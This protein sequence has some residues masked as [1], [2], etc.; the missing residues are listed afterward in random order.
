MPALHVIGDPVLHSRSPLIQ[1]AMLR[2]LGLDGEYTYTAVPVKKGELPAFLDLARAE[3][4]AGF[5]A[6]MPHKE[7]LVPLMDELDE[8]ARAIGAVNTVCLRGGKLVGH[9]TDGGGLVSALA[10]G[11][12]E[13]AGKTVV[14]LGAGGAAKAVAPALA[15]AGAA[16]VTVCNRT[17]DKASALCARAPGVL[18]PSDFDPASLRALCAGADLLV[19]ATNLGMAG[20]GQE[21][22]DLSFV[23]ALPEGAAVFDVVYNPLET[24]LLRRA[25]GR[26]LAAMNGLGMLL[27]QAVLALEFFLDAPLDRP[28]LCRAAEQALTDAK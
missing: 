16:R 26:G 20:T 22:A 9:N 8:A 28:A 24:A 1:T 21:F 19:N 11:G 17:L 3:G 13:A 15:A 14:L 18:V 6:T 23:D 7:D 5:N 2:R 25:K 27:H 4:C 12:R 10:D